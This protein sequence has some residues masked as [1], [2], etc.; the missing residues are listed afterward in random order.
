MVWQSLEQ[1]RPDYIGQDKEFFFWSSNLVVREIHLK[2]EYVGCP[3]FEPRP[4]HKLC[5]IPYQ[6]S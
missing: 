3:G 4:L 1:V 6:M 2:D 5:I